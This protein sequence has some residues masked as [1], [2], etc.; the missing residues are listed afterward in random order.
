MKENL[1]GQML[2]NQKDFDKFKNADIKKLHSLRNKRLI[3]SKTY[4]RIQIFQKA[5]QKRVNKTF[6][7]TMDYSIKSV[8][9]RELTHKQY[10]QYFGND[11]KH[12]QKPKIQYKGSDTKA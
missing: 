4:T 6:K 2:K 9:K 12:V 10:V 3:S 1:K 8:F 11:Y 5:Q 7:T